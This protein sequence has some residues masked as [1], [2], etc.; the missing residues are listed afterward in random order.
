MTIVA[1]D[2]PIRLSGHAT[3][4]IERR[5]FTRAEVEETIRGS[6]WLPAQ[7]E[8]LEASRD[9]PFDDEWNGRHYITKRVRAIFVEEEVE[10][11]VVT[12]YTYFF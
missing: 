12:V 10:I 1:R 8:R 4:Y 9:F 2:K 6:G 5:G 3:G 11:V 7:S